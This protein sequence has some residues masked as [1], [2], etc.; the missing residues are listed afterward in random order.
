[1]SVFPSE[2]SD[3]FQNSFKTEIL[4]QLEVCNS[5]SSGVW[6]SKLEGEWTSVSVNAANPSF[7]NAEHAKCI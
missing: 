2:E 4:R 3:V 1:M 5:A 7:E 6:C